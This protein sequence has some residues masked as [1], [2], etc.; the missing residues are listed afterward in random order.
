ML[1]TSVSLLAALAGASLA[2]A[3][4][5][6]PGLDEGPLIAPAVVEQIVHDGLKDSQVMDWL[7]TLSNDIGSRL[8]GS[9]GLD[10][11]CV[12]ARD[13]FAAMGLDARLEPWAELD[14]GFERGPSHG[15]LV[16]PDTVELEF[17]TRAW[18]VGTDGP[19][20]GAVLLAP[21]DE[22]ALAAGSEAYA[23]AWVLEPSVPREERPSQEFRE[24]R[25]DF[26]E[27]AGIAG[28]VLPSRSGELLVTSGSLDT[29]PD[30]A[31]P[32]PVVTILASSFD[33]LLTRLEEGQLPELEFDID[34]RFV[35]APPTQVNVIADLVG[36]V[37]PD[38]FIVVGGHI[39]TWD[40]AVGS[41]DNGTGVSTT[42][43]AARLLIAAGAQPERT[44]RFM[45]WGGEEQGLLGSREWVSQNEE[46]MP[47][48][49]A[50]LVHDGGTNSLSG[51]GVTTA[52]LPQATAAFAAV[53]DFSANIEGALPFTIETVGRL[54]GGGSDH[55]SFLAKGVPGFFWE[56]AGEA[57]YTFTHH[58]QHDNF[59]QAI[60]EYQR[61][62]SVVVAL[63][64]LGLANL[65]ERLSRRGMNRAQRRVG[66]GLADDG[67]TI[68][69]LS[70]SG[71]SARNGMAE[72]DKYLTVN[73]VD[74]SQGGLGDE[75]DKGEGRKMITWQ[76]GTDELS[77]IFEW[78]DG[79]ID[80]DPELVT[81]MAAD[82]VELHSDFY[83]GSLSGPAAGSALVLLHMNRSDR[84]AWL[85]L[86]DELYEAGIATL[87]IDMR[88]HGES[89]GVENALADRLAAG[90]R[91]LYQEMEQDAVA[92][93]AWLESLGYEAARM[94]LMGG[95]VG[96]S[97]ALR[98][99]VNDERLAG[100]ACLTPGSAYLGLDSAAD[101]AR[102]DNRSLL[103]VSSS[104]EAPGGALPLTDALLARDPWAP[105]TRIELPQSSIHGTRMFAVVPDIEGQLARWWSNV[106]R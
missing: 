60:P 83:A 78:D 71:L 56:Q 96:C 79:D 19:L 100:A 93:V 63:G 40:G 105:V 80:H 59:D 103:M 104:E 92:A 43:E 67:A 84:H 86:R 36:S 54:S 2:L 41:T 11:A 76:H 69:F 24:A 26:Y 87:A 39:D 51:I 57:N 106:L 85:P 68:T 9:V 88:G 89:V 74:V 82:G 77:G 55:S 16:A 25:T 95:S 18:S 22:E 70:A 32:I 1:L 73:G 30:D 34:N 13:E 44:I 12:W 17:I 48:I 52:Q 58:T 47:A 64:A 72:G 49:S 37:Y 20:R 8:T 65:P 35:S 98:A 94:G 101:I 28:Q 33:D 27:A 3:V 10:A 6:R 42:L 29:G 91:S 66:V 23:G 102:W 14:W 15:G 45:L 31:S 99:T 50:V 7:D 81:L 90:D 21:V 97:V 75:R 5:G 61:H 46:L 53:T 38:E 4:P 62:S